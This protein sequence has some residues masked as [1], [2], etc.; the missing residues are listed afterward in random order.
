MK[1]TLA[2]L[3]CTLFL[4]SFWA[5]AQ[6]P[7]LDDAQILQALTVANDLDVANGKLAEK[8]AS[9]GEVKS[10]ARRMVADHQQANDEGKT[11]SKQTKMSPRASALSDDLK[12]SGKEAMKEIHDLKGGDFDRAYI[13]NEVLLHQKVLDTIDN[14]LMPNAKDPSV[15]ALLSKVRPVIASHLE[16]AKKIQA[17]L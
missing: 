10:F 3:A 17:G 7:A 13:K 5:Q 2:I 15:K 16:H 11:V 9:N 8:K 1:K 12:A 4:P 6:Q 14:N